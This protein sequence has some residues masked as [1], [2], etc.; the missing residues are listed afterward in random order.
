MRLHDEAAAREVYLGKTGP[1]HLSF[2]ETREK[3]AFLPVVDDETADAWRQQ[4][5]QKEDDLYDPTLFIISHIQSPSVTVSLALINSY[6]SA[7]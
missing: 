6:I 7:S 3:S 1:L 5:K 2:A 4:D